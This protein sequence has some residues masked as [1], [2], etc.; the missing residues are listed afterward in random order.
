MAQSQEMATE[1]GEFEFLRLIARPQAQLQQARKVFDRGLDFSHLLL[2]SEIHGVRP[3][4][5]RFLES[6]Q[7]AAGVPSGIRASLAAFRSRHLLTT[8][9]MAG[10]LRR[11]AD[12]FVG[13]RIAFALFKGP[14]LAV[15]LGGDAAC[16]EYGDIDVM[17]PAKDV[18]SAERLLSALGYGN[19]QGDPAFCRWFLAS[20]GQFR[21]SRPGAVAAIDL[22][23]RFTR[24]HLPFPL[25]VAEIWGDL[26]PVSVGD[27]EVPAITGANLALLLA[28]HGTKERWS[29]LK[30]ILDFALMI[31]RC[32]SLD[33][34]DIHRRARRRGCGD[35]VL[36]AFSMAR[37]VLDVTAPACLAQQVDRSERVR[38]LTSACIAG[39]RAIHAHAGTTGHLADLAL[40]DASLDRLKSTLSLVM[41]PSPGDYGAMPFPRALWPAY[42][43]TRPL[44]LAAKTLAAAV[45][46]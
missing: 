12:L 29:S 30:W 19:P 8:L 46:S 32:P 10:E 9:A 24:R 22:H 38:R 28:G 39:L 44:R 37:H 18:A 20:Q 33:W 27:R 21:F 6:P 31:D 16:R 3:S 4:L 5:V 1:S 41:T 34:A 23:W 15:T 7:M 2:L 25:D 13:N 45:W 36:L 14:V 26:E 43:V 42:Y 17:I 11:L 35:S 40:C